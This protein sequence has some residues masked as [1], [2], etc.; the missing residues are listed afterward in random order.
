LLEKIDRSGFPDLAFALL[1]VNSDGP[2]PFKASADFY[3]NLAL[4]SHKFDKAFDSLLQEKQEKGG[5]ID[6]INLILL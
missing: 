5:S 1:G 2:S 3:F 6:L 4:R